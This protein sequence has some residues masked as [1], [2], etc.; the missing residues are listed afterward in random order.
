MEQASP[1]ANCR[2]PPMDAATGDAPTEF[3]ARR[4]T[5]MADAWD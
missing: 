3:V 4:N 1:V 5:S 2:P